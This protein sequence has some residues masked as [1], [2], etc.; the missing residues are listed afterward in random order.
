M[1]AGNML[2]PALARGELHCVGA[3]T[4]NEY[5]EYI[6]KDAA[7]ERR[8]Q[9][10]LVEE[11][12]EEDTIAI[13]RG[14]RERYEVHHGVDDHGYRGHRRHEA[15]AALHHRPPVA[16][17]GHRPD[18]RGREPHPHGDRLQAR[19]AGSTR[20]P[21][22]PA[23]DRA[24][25]RAQGR[26]PV[27][28]PAPGEDRGRDRQARARVRGA[29]RDLEGRKGHGAGLAPDQ[30]RAG[31][32]APRH[33]ERTPRGRPRAHVGIAVRHHPGAGEAPAAAGSW[34]P[35]ATRCSCC[36]TRSARRRSPRWCRSGP[37][38]RC[39]RCSRASGRSCC[40]WKRRCTGA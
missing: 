28:A 7:L 13:L 31:A 4:L 30:E 9:K 15:V 11:P 36:A 2:K 25:G 34:S 37:A 32:G 20:S 12:N 3:T 17:Q 22:D 19:S 16:G 27:G 10:V 18:R 6:E 29:R 39:R 23:E 14:L 1:D 33:G 8:F 24:R 21:P 35:A 40:A 38:S 26:G 5:R